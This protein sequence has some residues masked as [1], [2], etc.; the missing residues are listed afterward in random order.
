ML[1]LS[2]LKSS[3]INSALLLNMPCPV[4]YALSDVFIHPSASH[5][6]HAIPPA[7]R[8]LL[9]V[10][11]RHP[12]PPTALPVARRPPAAAEYA[13]MCGEEGGIGCISDG[14]AYNQKLKA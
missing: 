10:R 6:I 7:S 1:L 13:A 14:R 9:P 12:A 11:A 4:H 3:G 2:P 8:R 5:P